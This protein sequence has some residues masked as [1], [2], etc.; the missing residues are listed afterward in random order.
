MPKCGQKITQSEKGTAF[1]RDTDENVA[2]NGAREEARSLAVG[3]ATL[4]AAN[5]ARSCPKEC[6]IRRVSVVIDEMPSPTCARKKNRLG[7]YE[8][9]CQVAFSWHATV[10]CAKR[11]YP[12]P[13]DEDGQAIDGGIAKPKRMSCDEELWDEGNGQG[14]STSAVR[15]DA[16]KDAQEQA[17]RNAGL[18]AASKAKLLHCRSL[19]PAQRVSISFT[20]PS[21]PQ[22]VQQDNGEWSCTSYCDYK[23][24]VDC[25][26]V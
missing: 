1:S 6:P 5:Q 16:E 12:T 24:I 2:W 10:S 22:C 7:K 18:G 20:P 9:A 4:W 11:A 15:G 19:C 13:I 3:N 26:D 17:L 14:N 23:V 21:T 8:W 25:L